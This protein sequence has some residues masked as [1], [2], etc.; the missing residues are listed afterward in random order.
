ML[1]RV[2]LSQFFSCFNVFVKPRDRRHK[3]IKTA[4]VRARRK[5]H[6][7]TGDPIDISMDWRMERGRDSFRTI[8]LIS[9]GC[10]SGSRALLIQIRQFDST[11][12]LPRLLALSLLLRRVYLHWR[13]FSP[14][15][16][17]LVFFSLLPIFISTL[18]STTFNRLANRPH[19]LPSHLWAL[20]KITLLH[21]CFHEP[22]I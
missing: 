16:D 20:R 19:P 18:G 2:S 9:E 7:W 13:S 12:Y 22:F 6:V 15:S 10:T 4:H 11:L 14:S 5:A 1:L 17:I 8:L 21:L 3:Q